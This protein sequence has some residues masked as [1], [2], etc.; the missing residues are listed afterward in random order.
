M[1]TKA[2][3]SLQPELELI[4]Y[5]YKETTPEE[6]E[7]I[8]PAVFLNPPLQQEFEELLDMKRELDE[9]VFAPS[10]SCV[11]NILAFARKAIGK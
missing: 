8:V 7:A 9:V 11:N 6:R 5:L 3:V 10:E 2:N 1:Y 4:K